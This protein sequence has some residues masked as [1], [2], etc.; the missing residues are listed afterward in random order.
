MVRRAHSNHIEL[1]HIH[2]CFIFSPDYLQV[3][4]QNYKEI[5]AEIARSDLL[6]DILTEI[7]GKH[8]KV[9]KLSND[10]AKDILNSKYMLS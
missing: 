5:M 1:A 4:I 8:V 7:S 3:I 2:D 6:S 10:L 9:T